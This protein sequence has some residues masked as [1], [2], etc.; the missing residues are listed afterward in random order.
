MS[1]PSSLAI[2]STLPPRRR[3]HSLLVLSLLILSLL[4]LSAC[5]SARKERFATSP[6]LDADAGAAVIRLAA[7]ESISIQILESFPVQVRVIARGTL[8]DDCTTIGE[9]QPVRAG[10]RFH[11]A[12]MTQ[13]SGDTECHPEATS[14]EQM[15]SLE[16]QDLPAG[17]YVV[18]VNGM[19][20]SFELSVDNSA[21]SVE[22]E[23]ALAPAS[24]A[25]PPPAATIPDVAYVVQGMLAQQLD[26]APGAISIDSIEA[27][28]W[29]DACLGLAAADEAC[30]QQITPGYL[31]GLTAGEQRFVYRSDEDGSIIRS[32]TVIVPTPAPATKTFGCTNKAEFVSDVTVRDKT[33]IGGHQNF[34]KTWRLRN[35]G[36]CT[37]TPEY[38]IVGTGGD[39]MGKVTTFPLGQT[40][41]PGDVVQVSIRLV[42]PAR[43]GSYRSSWKLQDSTGALFGIGRNADQ[44]F[45][46]SIVVPQDATRTASIQGQVWHDLCANAGLSAESPP[47]G[48]RILDD[49]SYLADGRHDEAE[50]AIGGAI[51]TLGTGIC[52][53]TGMATTV[54]DAGGNYEFS[55][56][57][58]GEYCVSIDPT[59]D[60]NQPIFLPGAWSSPGDGQHSLSIGPGEARKE[61]DFGWDYQFAP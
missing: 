37:W 11:V 47:P 10:N 9:V 51:V 25:S 50:P 17:T 30:I 38:Q 12:I 4:V 28:E 59:S 41:A 14:F 36:T 34:V 16:T 58:P 46:V 26:I 18:D 32:E 61:V 31:I 56:L 19:T 29:P 48:C 44:A 27:R 53:A 54:A 42:A 3:R 60:H 2:A 23:S 8:P 22:I 21:R 57:L 15:I 33:R 45:W 24:P 35:G 13:S 1:V 6:G 5:G 43:K 55:K 39:A 20:D 7:V 49:G 40:V 52:P